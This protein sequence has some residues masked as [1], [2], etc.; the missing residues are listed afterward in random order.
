MQYGI[1]S[2]P[3]LILHFGSLELKR[4]KSALMSSGQI[5][6]VD[7]DNDDSDDNET[8]LAVDSDEQQYGLL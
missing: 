3:Y 7:D 8:R 4:G 2:R 6:D 5:N 1:K